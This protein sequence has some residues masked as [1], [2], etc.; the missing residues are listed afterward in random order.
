VLVHALEHGRI[1]IQYAP[2]TPVNT[3]GQLQS[4][5]DEFAVKDNDPRILLFQ[6]ET[7][8]PYQVAAVAWTH[9]LGCGT[10]TAKSLDAIRDFRAA[11]D[12]K[13]PEQQFIGPE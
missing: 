4:L 10:Y 11:Y 2:G 8:M 7:N 13:A 3:I 12:L 9:I 5:A 1:E 6:N